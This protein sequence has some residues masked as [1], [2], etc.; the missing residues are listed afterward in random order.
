MSSLRYGIVIQGT[1]GEFARY[2]ETRLA[3]VKRIREHP[4]VQ[5]VVVAVP[6]I[7]FD[8]ES[9]K[10]LQSLGIKTYVG[11][12]YNVAARVMKAHEFCGWSDQ[13]MVARVC[14][15]WGLLDLDLVDRMMEDALENPCS[16]LCTP[17]DFDYT[18]TAD[19]ASKEALYKIS[20]LPADTPLGYRATFNPWGYMEAFP[21]EFSNR[22]F[23][24]VP[25]YSHDLTQEKLSVYQNMYDENEFVAGAMQARDMTC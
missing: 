4:S 13:T 6:S 5:G 16:Y 10:M 12:D 17:K 23:K 24:D 15:S 25:L 22:L 18:V 1:L 14:A 11:E 20:I 19:I 9:Q 7:D 3:L 8:L 21:S 2:T